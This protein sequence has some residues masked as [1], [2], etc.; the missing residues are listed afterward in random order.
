[1]Q[2]KIDRATAVLTG[3]KTGR[4][5][6]TEVTARLAVIDHAQGRR[7]QAHAALDE[8][9]QREPGNARLLLLKG[10]LLFDEGHVD[11]AAERVNAAVLAEPRS[12]AAKYLLG[13]IQ[14][15]RHDRAAA[16]RTFNEVLSL[17]PKAVDPLLQLSRLYLAD[18]DLNNAAQTAEQAVKADG[19]SVPARLALVRA[20][21]ARRE[22]AGAVS[23]ARQAVAI[24]PRNAEAHGLLGT[25]LALNGDRQ[26]ARQS[27]ERALAADRGNLDAVGL[28]VAL[29]MA[30]ARQADARQFLDGYPPASQKSLP[31]LLVIGSGYQRLGNRRA[32]EAALRRAIEVDPSSPLPYSRLGG[33]YAGEG[34][35]ADAQHEFEVVCQKEPDSIPAHTMLAVLHHAGGD[36]QAARTEYEKV[37]AISGTAPVAANNLAWLYAEEGRLDRALELARG[38][39]QALPEQP[40]VSDTLGWV[41]YRKNLSDLAAA[42][43]RQSVERDGDNPVYHYH[44]GL[45]YAQGG[46]K[47]LA[48][49]SLDRALALSA[50]FEGADN[51]RRLAA[52]LPK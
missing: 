47:V 17:A 37:L 28:R 46:S 8:L 13:L 42:E 48:R 25:A 50:K 31:L 23:H 10:R 41:Y 2:G 44:L 18:Q 36:T 39:K 49:K 30:E 5:A 22:L 27:V 11:A 1:M 19:S 15:A 26:G 3:L 20:L 33:L 16:I 43:F 24:A 52:S 6:L 29:D 4:K 14:V 35:L 38:A 34:R 9:L 7:Q 45:A 32:A 21:V 12:A 40:E 51:A